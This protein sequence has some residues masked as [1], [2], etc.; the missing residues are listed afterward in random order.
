MSQEECD[1]IIRI[2]E[3]KGFEKALLNVGRGA[4]ILRDDV[5]RSGRCVIDDVDAAKI[6]WERLKHAIPGMYADSWR[7]VGLNER[8]RVLKYEEGDYFLPH[9]D[10][11]YQR[12][13]EYDN[14]PHGEPGDIS[15]FTLMLYLND[16]ERGGGTN[17]VSL[18]G[19]ISSYHP[20]TGQALIFDHGVSHEGE[21][22]EKGVKYA[23]RTD[24][25]YREVSREL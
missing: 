18:R 1:A 5:R 2:C 16:P 22:L 19:D 4:E 17:F 21:R 7:C 15:F 14:L 11:S 6:L 23:I 9:R 3:A 12:A 25:M 20:I 10:G 8:F 24:I 13:W